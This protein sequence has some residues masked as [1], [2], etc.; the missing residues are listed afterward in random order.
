MA[1]NPLQYFLHND[2]YEVVDV[3]KIS[4]SYIDP[5]IPL[6]VGGGGL[7]N[8]DFIGNI[9]KE[10]LYPADRLELERMWL[11]SWNLKNPTYA[12]DHTQFMERYRVLLHEYLKKIEYTDVLR[13]VWGAGFNSPIKEDE[14]TPEYPYGLLNFKLVGLRDHFSNMK[15]QWVPCASCMHP[16][17]RKKYPIRNHAIWFEHKKQLI[18]DFGD[19]PVPRFVNSGDNIEQTIE[20]LGS[21]E[22]ILTNSYHGAYW[23]TL[24]GKKVIAVGPWSNKFLFMKHPPRFLSKKENWKDAIDSTTEYPDALDECIS[25]NEKYWKQI[26]LSL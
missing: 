18:K 26:K 23:G 12:Q 15:H 7:L 4:E 11:D 2:E 13:F 5:N 6:I 21:A 3:T 17:L 16:A 8:N 10:I 20:L 9:F 25:A 22:V 24:L 1:S 19:E 14:L